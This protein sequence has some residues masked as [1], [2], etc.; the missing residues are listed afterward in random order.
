MEFETNT[1]LL[2]TAMKRASL[3]VEKKSEN[4]LLTNVK[5]ESFANTGVIRVTG[6]SLALNAGC[7]V[8][9][10]VGQTGAVCVDQQRML[11]IANALPGN[12]TAK[13]KLV[14]EGLQIRQSNSRYTLPV[15]SADEFPKAPK[16]KPSDA[17]DITVDLLLGLI[18]SVEGAMLNDDQRAHLSGALFEWDG[19]KAIMVATD[20]RRMYKTE[21]P[22]KTAGPGMVF[23]PHKAVVTL[24]KFCESIEATSTIQLQA[25][26][27]YLFFFNAVAGFSC[28]LIDAKRMDYNAAIPKKSD[29]KMKLPRVKLMDAL[30]RLKVIS[31][32]PI[33]LFADAETGKLELTTTSE[34]GSGRELVKG[35]LQGTGETV[36]SVAHL[37]D[38]LSTLTGD[39]VTIGFTGVQRPAVVRPAKA[40]GRVAIMMPLVLH[41]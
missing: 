13:F 39:Q 23:I 7:R 28:K 24:R 9:G 31:E 34:S 18:R 37:L 15:L 6:S 32:D 22:F 36:L 20:S 33:R 1:S 41:D 3:V 27:S 38:Y 35:E 26:T 29:V 4:P 2:L 25:G 14:D 10:K 12:K 11:D 30:S 21:S 8:E 5:V 17:I 16:P 40:S 19:E